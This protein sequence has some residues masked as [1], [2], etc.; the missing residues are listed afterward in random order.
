M[1]ID[2]LAIS[3]YMPL[4]NLILFFYHFMALYM[5]GATMNSPQAVS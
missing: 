1:L 4:D 5:Y 3:I 2:S